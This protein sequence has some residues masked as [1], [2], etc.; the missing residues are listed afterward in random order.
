MAETLAQATPKKANYRWLVILL[1]LAVIVSI[2]LVYAENRVYEPANPFLGGSGDHVHAFAIDPFQGQHMYMGTHYGFFRTGDGGQAWTRLTGNGG[3][4][5]TLIVTSLTISPV[6]HQIT[7][8]TGYDLDSG[9]ASGIYVTTDDGA[10]WQSLPTGGAE[11]LPDPRILFVTAGWADAQEAYTYSITSGLYQTL[12]TGKHWQQVA[13]AFTGQVTSFTPFLNCGGTTVTALSGKQCPENFLVGTTKG[14]FIGQATNTGIH[15]DPINQVSSYVYAVTI[16]R[17]TPL[18]FYASTQEGLFRANS[19]TE[20]YTAVSSVAQGAPTLTSISISGGD[21]AL[22]YGITK[23]NEVQRSH[24]GG[25]TWQGIGS[26]LLN[27]GLS[28]LSSGLRSATGSNTPQWAGGQNVF[29][30]LLQTP[31]TN[32][33]EVYAAISFPNQLFYSSQNGTNWREIHG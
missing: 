26:S 17:S 1:A 3:V 2:I 19:P 25:Q 28:Q 27:R 31:A 24:D 12:D 16:H 32:S 33:T 5:S 7:Y 8:A 4:P 30:T 21:V 14:L 18:T 11:Q 9:N 6:D 13:P 29:L 20:P 10:N 22:L 15:F 23:N